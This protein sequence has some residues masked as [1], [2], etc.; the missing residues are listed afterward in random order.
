MRFLAS[1]RLRLDPPGRKHRARPEDLKTR[2]L[3]LLFEDPSAYF[4]RESFSLAELLPRLVTV[5]QSQDFTNLARIEQGGIDHFFDGTGQPDDLERGVERFRE[6]RG[7]TL[8]YDGPLLL[9]LEKSEDDLELLLRVEIRRRH[10]LQ[11]YPLRLDFDGLT[12]PGL[13]PD[14]GLGRF[15]HLLHSFEQSLRKFLRVGEL[16]TITPPST[17]ETAATPTPTA[18]TRPRKHQEPGSGDGL[19]FPLYGITLGVTTVDELKRM[20]T[21]ATDRDEEGE[22]FRYFVINDMN[23]WYANDRAESI[24]ITYSDAMPTPWQALGFDWSKSYDDWLNTLEELGCFISIADP[25]KKIRHYSGEYDSF[26][27]DVS[28]LL[29]T[30]P[31]TLAIR[32]SFDYSKGTSVTAPSTLYSISV[33]LR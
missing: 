31:G 14:E 7:S 4:I 30:E 17:N 12:A 24:Y 1:L 8:D 10:A 5:L 11:Q 20:G 33:R 16:E 9:V 6:R 13:D 25:P 15:R 23:F 32:L 29:K 27:A 21:H 3:G 26:T 28:G 2:L 18:T 19:L 22:L